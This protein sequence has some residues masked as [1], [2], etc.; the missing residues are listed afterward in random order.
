MMSSWRG[1]FIA[2]VILAIL[3]GAYLYWD[4]AA[5]PEVPEPA[6]PEILVTDVDWEDIRAIAVRWDDEFELRIERDEEDRYRMTAPADYPA[7]QDRARLLFKSAAALKADRIVAEA[8][9]ADPAEYGLDAPT[10]H[11]ILEMKDGREISADIG[12][13]SPLA[14]DE[15]TSRYAQRDGA[16][17]IYL[18]PGIRL[19]FYT[20][21]LDRWRDPS[22][23][24]IDDVNEVTMVAH[25]GTWT[26]HRTDGAYEWE[27]KYPHPVPAPADT[28]DKVVR[29]I[30]NLRVREFVTDD[31]TD[32]ELEEWNLVEGV[33]RVTLANAEGE[34]VT[35]IIGGFSDTRGSEAY[36]RRED[37]R[38]V[39]IC[40]TAFYAVPG[41]TDVREWIV[42]KPFSPARR[43]AIQ[44]IEVTRGGQ[45]DHLSPSEAGW[46]LLT[47]DGEESEISS[48]VGNALADRFRN[49]AITDIIWPD[50]E[51]VEAR[52]SLQVP[53]GSITVRFGPAG[54]TR[55]ITL[56]IAAGDTDESIYA[57]NL[58]YDVIY[59]LESEAYQLLDVS[60]VLETIPE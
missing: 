53:A 2:V 55:E 51:A 3:G 6:E 12:D 32:A 24:H 28:L 46:T 45:S 35:V 59:V 39:Y 58:E 36:V 17:D 60:A 14:V 25:R 21:P 4:A 38:S 8:G 26:A 5:E 54:E 19:G 31:P 37:S 10:R 33:N 7:D 44:S 29:E 23:V 27:L 41:F 40:A 20:A 50:E 1:P 13:A 52:E 57:R 9:E 34:E 22:V 43:D 30:R 11:I 56:V 47:A 42:E 18:I 49:L 48:Q 15:Y 16:G